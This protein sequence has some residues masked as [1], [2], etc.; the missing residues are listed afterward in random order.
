MILEKHA[1]VNGNRNFGNITKN[2][3]APNFLLY[4]K[5]DKKY[6]VIQEPIKLESQKSKAVIKTITRHLYHAI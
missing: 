1:P 6:I 2:C 3:N 5:G 4:R